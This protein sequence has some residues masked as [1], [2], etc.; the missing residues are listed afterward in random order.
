MDTQIQQTT[1][2]QQIRLPQDDPPINRLW[3]PLFAYQ[4]VIVCL[5]DF[6]MFP[7]MTMIWSYYNGV[8]WGG[9]EPLTLKGSGLYHL[10]AGGVIGVSS[11]ARGL[12][13]ALRNKLVAQLNMNSEEQLQ[14]DT[15]S[16][17]KK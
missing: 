1:V 15:K 9:W 12:D 11:Y 14:N 4:Y 17:G 5:F 7:L 2:S 10:A 3:R 6:M 16:T 13:T 8:Q